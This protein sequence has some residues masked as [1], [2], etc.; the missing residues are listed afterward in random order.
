MLQESSPTACLV[1]HL[2]LDTF[3]YGGLKIRSSNLDL[4]EWISMGPLRI[5]YVS[6]LLRKHYVIIEFSGYSRI[7]ISRESSLHIA[8]VHIICNKL[9]DWKDVTLK[10]QGEEYRNELHFKPHQRDM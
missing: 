9:L 3:P 2:H 4:K 7:S 10:S 5:Y 6:N 1:I 8:M